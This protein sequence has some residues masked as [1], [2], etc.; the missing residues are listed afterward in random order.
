MFAHPGDVDKTRG[1][2]AI[3]PTGRSLQ[4]GTIA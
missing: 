1:K 4:S 2:H 3:P